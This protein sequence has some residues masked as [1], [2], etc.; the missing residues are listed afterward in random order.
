MR[1]YQ[2][3]LIAI[4][5]A[6]SVVQSRAQ[7][8][9]YSPN[10]QSSLL[11]NLSGS[12]SGLSDW[13]V[14]GA[15]QLNQQWFYYSIGSSPV[16]S[17]DQIASPSSVNNHGGAAPF[18]STVYS[19]STIS[20]TAKFQLNNLP[21]FDRSITILNPANSGQTQDFHFYQYSDFDLGGVSGGQSVQFSSNG[22]G[23][24]YQVN[25]TG[26]AAA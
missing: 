9:L 10:S 5:F 1:F 14:G 21:T 25:Q 12:S 24:P 2:N 15:S 17:I 6:G 13:Q 22:S 8:T 19:N 16:Y 20:V 18:L 7:Y 26:L 23:I 3:T 11:I 4:L